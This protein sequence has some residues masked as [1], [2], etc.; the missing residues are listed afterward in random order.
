MSNQENQ[1]YSKI[2]SDTGY[3]TSTS[4]TQLSVTSIMNIIA[5]LQNQIDILATQIK[6][7]QSVGVDNAITA[8]TTL[9]TQPLSSVVANVP[10]LITVLS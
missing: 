4:S 10:S 9:S 8:I 2:D 6:G 3:I 1:V 7:L 5:D